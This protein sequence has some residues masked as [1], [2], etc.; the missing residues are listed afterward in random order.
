MMGGEACTGD[1]WRT[2][3][4][5][6]FGTYHTVKMARRWRLAIN[7]WKL[8]ICSPHLQMELVL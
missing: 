5:E 2:V 4:G 8:V 6:C 7:N 3:G 1:L